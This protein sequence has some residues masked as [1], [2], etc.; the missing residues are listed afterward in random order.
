MKSTRAGAWIILLLLAGCQ[1]WSARFYATPDGVSYLDLSDAVVS[2]RLGELLN[3]YWSPL[4]PVLIGVLRLLLRPT[5]YSEFAVVHLLNW[6]LFALS[7]AGFEY[8]LAGIRINGGRESEVVQSR[9]G[10]IGAY[11]LFGAFSLMMMPLTL[12]TPDLLVSAAS[13]VAFGALLRIRAGSNLTR[14]ASVLGV[15]LVVGSLTKSFVIPWTGVC[16][17]VAFLATRRAGLRPAVVATAIWLVAVMP[18]TIGLSGKTGHLTFGDTGR[19][20]YVWYVN[21]VESPSLK[22]MP[23][24]AATPATDSVLPGVAIIAA[25]TGTNPV[26][27]DPA[28]WY[29]H[30]R[31]SFDARRQMQVFAMLVAEY[32]A[33]L[34]PLVIVVGFWLLVAAP[35]TLGDWWNR[36]WVVVV[37]SIAAIVAYSLVL[38]TTRYVAPFYMAMALLFL[39]GMAWP[40]RISPARAA[41]GIGVPL[42]LMLTTPDPGKAVNLVNAAAG[43]VL[44]VWLA[45][46]RS[47]LVMVVMGVI[48]ALSIRIL[49]PGN[50]VRFV[51]LFSLI[52]IA[53]Y[54]I[55][56]RESERRGEGELHSALFRRGLITVNA[57]LI[58]LVAGLKYVDS[59][60][61]PRVPGSGELNVNAIIARQAQDARIRP[62]DRI[63]VIGSPFEAYWA[64]AMGVKVVAVVPPSRMD[65]F[66]RLPPAK[67]EQLYAVFARAG[68]S[69]VIAQQRV[70][71]AGEVATWT[72]ASYLGW[73]RAISPP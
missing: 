11:A 46:Y 26:W 51:A 23:S 63:A 58:L 9:W 70:A 72:L 17:I 45:R 56:A 62:G 49:Q 69:H 27:Y 33:S 4:Y 59:L 21:R 35:G 43:A 41:L 5:P 25:G 16:L 20:T 39:A 64:R 66:N 31:P 13:F 50:A 14:S 44:F 28:R 30:L 18:W 1:A 37:P 7:I 57:V 47:T 65:D 55:A 22:S 6:L 54:W 29:S 24:S 3:A 40:A 53:G 60:K 73:V 36:T 19:L 8:F 10:S 67:R 2:G 32:L 52:V 71:P 61:Q 15:A 42:L 48:G 34:A 68:A 12:P 38:V